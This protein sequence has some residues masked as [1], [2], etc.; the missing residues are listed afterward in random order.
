MKSAS[1]IRSCLGRAVLLAAAAAPVSCWSQDYPIRPIRFIVGFVPGGIADLMARSLGQKLTEAWGQQVIIDNRAGAG[2]LI[3]MQ[4][5]AK[6]VPDGYTLLMG[7]STQFSINPALRAGLPYDPIRDYTPLTQAALTP[8]ILTVQPSHSARSVQELVQLAKAKPG[9]V[10]IYASTGY[11]GAPHI[12][13]ELLKR[14]AGIE[15]THVPYK[16]GGD[17]VIA[18]MGGHVQMSFG[19]VSTSLAHI[20]GGRLRALGVTSLKRLA[21]TPE[22][23]TFAEAGL[24]GFEVVQWYGVFAPAGLPSAITRKTSETLGRALGSAEFKEHF[25]AQGIEL[26]H[27]TPEAFAA[28]VKV[29]LARWTRVLKEMGIHEA[30]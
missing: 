4:I 12:A 21:A 26:V 14:V 23:P 17:A 5:A 15:M 10:M 1:S 18:L 7:S 25:A 29:E 27:S 30:P 9:Q 19:A 2:G 24:P 20:R 16:G 8:V 13:A 11:G 6:A 28:Y 22:V 3:S